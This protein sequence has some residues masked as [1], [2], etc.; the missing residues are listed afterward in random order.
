[1]LP[2]PATRT[3][4]AESVSPRPWRNGCG[5]TRELV[6]GPGDRAWRWR[7]SLADI[8]ADGPF[9]AFPGVRRWFAVVRGGGVELAFD[10]ETR[11]LGPD[12]D[13]IA[14]DG[15]AAPGCR[16]P[17]GPTRDLNLMLADGT[18]GTMR[19][20]QRGECWAEE[21]PLRGF[22][23]T[24]ALVLHWELPPGAL[25]ADGDGLWIGVAP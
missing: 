19:R 7:V 21:W 2:A 15:A 18:A 3:I 23:D 24:A 5:R 1:M 12:D 20:A 4:D 14:F 17:G 9:S 16:L 8:E 10:G 22:F 25:T 11:R 6:A 13:P